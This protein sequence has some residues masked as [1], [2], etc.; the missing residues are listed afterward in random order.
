MP[1]ESPRIFV[2]DDDRAVLSLVGTSV[3][4]L[5]VLR[6]LRSARPTCEAVLTTGYQSV[7]AAVEALRQS[8]GC[9]DTPAL[10]PP[11]STVVPAP[12]V[13]VER[14]HILR[15]LEVVHGNKAVAARLLGMSR[16]ALYRL[17]ERHGLHHRVQAPRHSLVP[18]AVSDRVT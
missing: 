13:E 3:S 7:D 10:P 18:Q 15:T 14:D 5:E 12:L 9:P 16:R 1:Q 2:V 17:L 6:A 8:L 11:S 4:C